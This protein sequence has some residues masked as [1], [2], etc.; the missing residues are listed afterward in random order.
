MQFDTILKGGQVFDGTGNPWQ[1]VDIGITGDLITAMGRLDQSDTANRIDCTGLAVCPGFIDMHSHS[2]LNILMEPGAAPKIR[3]GVTTEVIGQDGIAVAP[4]KDK[5]KKSWQKHMSGLAGQCNLDWDWNTLSEYF[6]RIEAAKP[7]TNIVS[8]VPHGHLRLWVMGMDN[9]K[10][11]KEEL[12]LMIK[13]L[14]QS[15]EEGAAGMSTGLI[16]PPCP[17]AD[18][19]ELIELCKVVNEHGK[20]FVAHMRNE[21]AGIMDA[22]DEMLAIA[23]GSGVPVHISHL[24]VMNIAQKP[25]VNAMLNKLDTARREGFELTF[26][27]YPYTAGSTMLFAILP[28]WVQEG[29]TERMLERLKDPVDRNTIGEQLDPF[30]SSGNFNVS[31]IMVTVESEKNRHL[32]GKNLKEV[33]EFLDKPL[34]EAACD[35]LVEEELNV[36]MIIE[37]QDL[38]DMKT[39]LKHSSGTF[40][41]DGLLGSHPHPR[42][43]GAFPRILGRYCREERLLEMS[44]AIRKMTSAGAQR[45]GIKDRGLVRE[46]FKADLIVFDPHSIIDC[47]TYSKPKQFPKGIC[48]VIVNGRQVVDN[49]QQVVSEGSGRVLRL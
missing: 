18:I 33:A 44:E 15:L 24:K 7:T 43:Y 20:F 36:S 38:E 28:L 5:D 14:R 23:K 26:D 34:I 37:S 27:Q 16:Y 45:L 31:N 39:I 6:L 8:Y 35:L 13:L 1:S 41:T 4:I 9:R 10:A 40:C 48:H 47:A 42:V 2:D 49:E 17:F 30:L 19:E 11:K 22:M 25:D 3:Q 32:V 21:D 46:G 12:A 29:G